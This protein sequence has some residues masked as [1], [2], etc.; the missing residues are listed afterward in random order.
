MTTVDAITPRRAARGTSPLLGR[1]HA[2]GRWL[3]F[4]AEAFSRD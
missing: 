1:G 4:A 2:W 3:A